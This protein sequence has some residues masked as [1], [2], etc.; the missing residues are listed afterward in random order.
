MG[1]YI[2]DFD[3]MRSEDV[4]MYREA[5]WGRINVGEGARII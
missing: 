4:I 2:G 1:A 3:G 5:G